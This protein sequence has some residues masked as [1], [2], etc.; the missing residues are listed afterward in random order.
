[1]H[2]SN[3][4]RFFIALAMLMVSATAMGCSDAEAAQSTYLPIHE[5]CSFDEEISE[6]EKP[7]PGL[8]I[9]SLEGLIDDD[10]EWKE[11]GDTDLEESTEQEPQADSAL[12]VGSESEVTLASA[13]AEE[14]AQLIDINHAGA[15]ELTEIPGIG[16]ALA[17]RIL[18]Y[19]ANR[20]FDDPAQL[21]RIEGIG[22]ATLEKIRPHVRAD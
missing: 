11:T 13:P 2:R 14:S 7:I 8:D 18:D 6:S 3:S 20:R 17:Q 12:F 19:R 15:D 1:M 4:I 9:P 16:P 22:P 5:P 21:T 10:V